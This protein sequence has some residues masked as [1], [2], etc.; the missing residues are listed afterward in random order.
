MKRFQAHVAENSDHEVKEEAKKDEE[1]NEE[2]VFDLFPNWI[3]LT[4]K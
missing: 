2:Y 1:S 4:R 3:S